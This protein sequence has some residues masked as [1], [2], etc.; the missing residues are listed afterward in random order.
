MA[1]VF[2]N[3][4]EHVYEFENYRLVPSER[5]LLRDGHPVQLQPKIFE[6][7]LALVENSGHLVEKDDLMARLWPDTFV[8]E[9]TLSRNISD[10]RRTLGESGNKYKFIVTVPKCGY[11]FVA[12]VQRLPRDEAINPND[13]IVIEE[14]SY[15]KSVALVDSQT[16]TEI[17]NVQPFWVTKKT[18]VAMTFFSFVFI[19]LIALSALRP[20][21]SASKKTGS[22]SSVKSIAVLPFKS[23]NEQGREEPLELGMADAL[24]TRLSN[25]KQINI[26]PSSAIFKYTGQNADSVEIGREL[27][28]EAVLDGSIQRQGDRV[29]VSVQLVNVTDGTTLWADKFDTKITDFFAMQDALSE[30]ITRSLTLHLTGTEQNTLAKYG[31]PNAEAYQ[32]YM[33]G[34]FWFGKNTVEGYRKAIDNF[35]QAITIDNNYASAYAGLADVYSVQTSVGFLPP[36]EG[37]VKAKAAAEKAVELD[38]GSAQAHISLGHLR[39]LTWDW[40]GAEKEFQRAVALNPSAPAAHLWYVIYLSSLGRHQEAFAL[41]KKAQEQNPVSIIINA[42]AIRTHLFARQYDEAIAIGLKT[43]ELEP[44]H[45]ESMVWLAMAYENKGLYDEAVNLYL[46][47][48]SLRGIGTEDIETLRAA[49]KKSGWRG[50]WVKQIEIKKKRSKQKYVGS[51]DFAEMYIRVGDKETAFEWLEKAYLERSDNLTLLKFSPVFDSLRSDPR[52]TDLIKRIW[53]P[54]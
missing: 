8:E 18:L 7:L 36:S 46:K 12:N 44:N 19:A 30:Q 24:I 54:D 2:G 9:A 41:L 51:Y 10:L 32:F 37:L 21:L 4:E 26:R 47:R 14:I 48:M 35:N 29:R 45:V 3:L 6:T 17:N 34:R 50:Y 43:L 49:Y 11:R 28:V 13:E 31:T 25:L 1:A 53:F 42:C 39:T 22:A 52:Y 15:K 23:M 33:K 40:A 20:P 38:D 16:V 5:L 27:N